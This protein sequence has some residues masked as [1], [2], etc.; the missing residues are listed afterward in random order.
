MGILNIMDLIRKLKEIP[1]KI[2]IKTFT[3]HIPGVKGIESKK[4]A[5]YLS[6]YGKEVMKAQNFESTPH[7]IIIT[8][9]QYNNIFV[10]LFDS[11]AETNARIRVIHKNL[12]ED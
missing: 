4:V 7:C 5:I 8:Q 10:P 9:D 1:C 11:I 12:N 2:M 6:G 3:E